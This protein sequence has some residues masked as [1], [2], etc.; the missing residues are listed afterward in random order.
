V[1]VTTDTIEAIREALSEADDTPEQMA[2]LLS[3]VKQLTSLVE[4][5]H[6]RISFLEREQQRMENY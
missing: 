5:L 1:S 2:Y 4:K 6:A 3:A